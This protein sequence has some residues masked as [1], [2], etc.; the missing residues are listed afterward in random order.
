MYANRLV[1]MIET[2]SDALANGLMERVLN[3]EKLS[4]MRKVPPQ[5]LRQ[6]AYEVYRHLSDWLLT[7]TEGDI[8]RCYSAIG[9]RRAEQGVALSHFLGA[10]L[11]VKEHLR[12]FL[13]REG[14][15][16]R[17][18]ELFLEMEL[19]EMVDQFFDRALYYAARGYEQ[20]SKA[21]SSQ[22]VSSKLVAR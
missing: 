13:R 6:R 21:H 2:H 9:K 5:E 15:V 10:I 8:E 7:K 4:D 3:S 20:A 19:L 12:A 1:Q 14:L 22:E 16:D 18:V 11:A 17:H